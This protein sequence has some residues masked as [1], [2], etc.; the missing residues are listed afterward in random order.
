MKEVVVSGDFTATKESEN[1]ALPFRLVVLEQSESDKVPAT[2]EKEIERKASGE[3]V[4]YN[5]YSSSSQ[6]L[7]RRTRFETQDGRNVIAKPTA[8][9]QP[10]L[11]PVTLRGL[12]EGGD[13]NSAKTELDRQLNTARPEMLEEMFGTLD[14]THYTV[15]SNMTEVLCARVILPR[16]KP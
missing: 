5:A 10:H 14:M 15:S 9:A 13:F 11:M 1:G 4:I 16:V 8:G 7:I 12:I 6:K 3:I 2:Q